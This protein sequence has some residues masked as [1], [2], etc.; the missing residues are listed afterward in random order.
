MWNYKGTLWNS[1]QNILPIHWKIGFLHNIEIL[2]AL[3]FKS[4]YAFLKRPPAPHTYTEQRYGCSPGW[5]TGIILCMRQANER[6]RYIITSSLIG[7]AHTQSDRWDY[8]MVTNYC[9][10]LH[11]HC[12]PYNIH[13]VL[14]CFCLAAVIISPWYIRGWIH[15]YSPEL[16]HW[17]VH[18]I[19]VAPFTNMV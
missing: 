8:V 13:A 3:R 4:S 19:P 6:R 17:L 18:I 10:P 1:T 15:P 5:I 14:M 2:S 9:E 16:L 11:I 7:W 12:V